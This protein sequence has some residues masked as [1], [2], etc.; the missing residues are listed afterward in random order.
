MEQKKDPQE[1]VLPQIA[2]Q[3]CFSSFYHILWLPTTIAL[4]EGKVIVRDGL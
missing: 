4:C 3:S 1:Y 2:L